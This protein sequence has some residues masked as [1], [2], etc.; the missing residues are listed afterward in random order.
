MKKIIFYSWQ[1]DLPNATNRSFIEVALKKA[2]ATITADRD[3]EVEPVVERD[4]E[5]VAGAPDISKTILDKIDRAAMFVGDVSIINQGA[6]GRPTPN[7]NVLVELGYA[8][9]ALGWERVSLVMNSQFGGPDLLPFDLKMRRV[10]IYSAS[11]NDKDRTPAKK[12]LEQTLEKQI[13]SILEVLPPEPLPSQPHENL[14][15]AI[16]AQKPTRIRKAREYMEFLNQALEQNDRAPIPELSTMK[17]L[18]K[19]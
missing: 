3:I 12:G 18:S 13:R 9:K 7:P 15:E 19:P 6:G 4:T 11:E 2:A 17:P 16:E 8:V 14:I 10:A 1:S 5:G